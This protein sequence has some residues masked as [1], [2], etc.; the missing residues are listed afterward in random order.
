MLVVQAGTA[1]S[2]RTR[3]EPNAFN[4]LRIERGRIEVEQHVLRDGAFVR[5]ATQAFCR[6]NGGWRPY[7]GDGCSALSTGVA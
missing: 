7:A 5:A 6:R 3:E 2:S 1:T 4:L